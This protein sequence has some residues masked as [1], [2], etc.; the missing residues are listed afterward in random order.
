[1]IFDAGS[2]TL[3]TDGVRG[4]G[5]ESGYG[6]VYPS[7]TALRPDPTIQIERLSEE[8][9]TARVSAGC[10]SSP[11]TASASSPTTPASSRTLRTSCC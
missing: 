1:M 5:K 2:K 3:T 8:H 7:L 10:R 6:L 4:F 9:A 11:A